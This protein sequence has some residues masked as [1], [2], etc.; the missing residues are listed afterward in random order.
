MPFIRNK[1]I[2][3]KKYAYLVENTWTTK[4]P[5]QK[6]T[7]YLGQ[8]IEFQIEAEPYTSTLENPEEF[9]RE[10]SFK[11]IVK[12]TVKYELSRREFK[13]SNEGFSKGDI[14]I[15]KD[16]KVTINGKNAV[17][18]MNRGFLCESTVNELLN[19]DGAED[20]AG[21]RLAKAI[22]ACGIKNDEEL[23]IELFAKSRPKEN[24]ETTIY[25]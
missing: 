13:E 9:L 6:V 3:G 11:E 1:R 20:A 18:Q 4:G 16:Y 8:V 24:K 5:R 7:K 14:K 10:K 17:L 21:K 23:F 2:K 19:Y 22:I 25:Y 15:S 12:N